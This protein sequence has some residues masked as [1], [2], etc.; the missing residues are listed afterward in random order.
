MP[1]RGM[2]EK[3]LFQRLDR[4]IT[5]LQNMDKIIAILQDMSR[6]PPLAYRIVNGLA[7]GAGILSILTVVEL[8]RSWVGG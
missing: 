3:T 8:I 2:N 7:I 5:I 4:I 1:L 6:P